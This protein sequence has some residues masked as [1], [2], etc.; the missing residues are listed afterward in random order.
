MHAYMYLYTCVVP[1]TGSKITD[2]TQ[3]YNMFVLRMPLLFLE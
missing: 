3:H 2:T 1:Y